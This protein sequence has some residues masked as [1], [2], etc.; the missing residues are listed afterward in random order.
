MRKLLLALLFIFIYLNNCVLF[1]GNKYPWF[2]SS[3]SNINRIKDIPCPDKYKRIDLPVN[4]FAVWLRNLPLKKKGKPVYLHNGKKKYNQT[5]HYRVIDIDTGSR[6]LQQCADALMRLRAEYLYSR[7]LFGKIHF[8][9]VNKFRADYL[10]WR[11]GYRIKVKGNK[12]WWAKISVHK[13]NYKDFRKYLNMV[14]SYANTYSLSK[15][16]KRVKNLNDIKVG[17]IFIQGGFP[18][19][20]VI[21]VDMAKNSPGSII[22]LLAQSYMPAQDFHVLKS[23]FSISPWYNI[24]FKGKLI[25]PEWTFKKKD[26]KRFKE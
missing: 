25:T 7:Q 21:V 9:F 6:D 14:F 10:K 13:N 2:K 22:F 20:A 12:C 26:L 3:D 23:F 15:E 19:H 17:D 24:N 4:S 16:M 5:A 1:A 18:G 8:N 11:Q